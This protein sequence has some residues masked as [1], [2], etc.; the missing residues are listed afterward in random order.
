MPDI[1][2]RWN[3]AES[4]ADWV[5][6]GADLASGP[7]IETAVIISLFTDREA[8]PDDVIPDGTTDPRGWWGDLGGDTKIGSRLWELDREKQSDR[9]LQ[10]AP[11][12]AQEALEWL[13]ADGIVSRITAVAS[14]IRQ[15][16]LGLVITL[17]KPTGEAQTVQV[18]R[19][20][21]G[22]L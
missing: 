20:W 5:L 2:T 1:A 6:E 13:V 17:F 18:E 9:V 22:T 4:T 19:A 7:D 8:D 15:G 12:L 11:A 21:Q 16:F 3:S 14:F 10:R